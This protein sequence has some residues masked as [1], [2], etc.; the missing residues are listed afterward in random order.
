MTYRRWARGSHIDQA[1]HASAC[2]RDQCKDVEKNVDIGEVKLV[3]ANAYHRRR[4]AGHMCTCSSKQ[5]SERMHKFG[6]ECDATVCLSR[7][8]LVLL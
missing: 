7:Y 1:V 5:D 2:S 3:R 4:L 6:A 8:G